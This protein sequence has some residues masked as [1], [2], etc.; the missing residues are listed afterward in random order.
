MSIEESILEVQPGILAMIMGIVSVVNY[1]FNSHRRRVM[2]CMQSMMIGALLLASLLL[3]TEKAGNIK[4]WRESDGID[5]DSYL[6]RIL[7][8]KFEISAL[9]STLDAVAIKF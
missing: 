2:G 5:T 8:L 7:K 6:C 9:C 4:L 1:L 3:H